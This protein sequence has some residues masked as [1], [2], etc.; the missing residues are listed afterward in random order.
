M[1]ISAAFSEGV[2]RVSRA[3][4]IL[5]GVLALTFLVALPLGLALRAMLS[6]HLGA[7][8]AARAAASSVNYDWWEEFSAQAQGVGTSFS[9]TILGFGAVLANL[10]A[11]LDN[12]GQ[13]PVVAAAGVAYVILWV[14]LAGGILDRYA[15][16]RP[17]RANGFF[18]RCGAFF[19]RFLR[20]AAMAL[21][22]Y[23]LLY[24]YVH[25]W[26]F[27]TVYP[28]VIRDFTV[29]RSAF[30]VRVLLYLAFGSLLVACNVVFDYAKIRAVVEDRRSMI[31]ALVAGLRFV[32]RRPGKVAGLYILNGL[33]FLLVILAYAIVAPGAGGVGWSL[34]FGLLVSQ[35]YLLARLWVKLLFYASQTALFQ[36]EL[37]HAEYIA[38]PQPVWPE[39]PAAE[40]IGGP[41]PA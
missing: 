1:T 36:G 29:E 2:R 26:L 5:A 35:L 8:L 14:F 38:A 30:F 31:G 9:P 32:A 25:A 37:A 28:W 22:A 27:T 21:F 18:S 24:A 15:R 34:W 4:A 11:M 7:S 6:D 12:R 20:L 13:V 23:W 41:P 17:L 39:S 19:F 10:S 40:A 16:N 33:M 3:P